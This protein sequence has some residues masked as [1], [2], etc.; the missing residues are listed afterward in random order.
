VGHLSGFGLFGF[1]AGNIYLFMAIIMMLLQPIGHLVPVGLPIGL[2]KPETHA[3]GLPEIQPVLG[4]SEIESAQ[5]AA[6]PLGGFRPAAWEDFETILQKEIMRRPSDGPVYLE[7]DPETDWR[8]VARTV[9]MIRG[10]QA[11]VI[12]LTQKKDSQ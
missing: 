5:S 9:D 1:M 4:T 12:L 8:S 7:G 2:L 11:Q 10:L 3:V 6:R